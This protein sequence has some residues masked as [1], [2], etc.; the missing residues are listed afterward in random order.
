[1]KH[2]GHHLKLTC[3]VTLLFVLFIGS[4]APCE[5]RVP[6][7]DEAKKPFTII[8]LP[9]TQIY[10]QSF[11]DIFIKQTEW[12]KENREK[13]NIV[14]VLHEGDIT[15]HN[16]EP[17]WK[18][19]DK[20]MSILDDVVPYCMAPGNHD[21]GPGGGRGNFETEFLDKFFPPS[22]FEK[23]PWYG[24]VYEKHSIK[25][26]YYYIEANGTR[27]LVVCLEFGPRDKVLDWANKIVADNERLQTIVLTHNYM[28]SDDTRVGEGDAWNPHGYPN[29]G[30]DGEDMWEKFVSRHKNIFLVV[31]GHILHDGLGRLTSTGKN[32]NKVHQVLANYQMRPKGGSGWLRIMTFVPDKNKILVTTYSPL[33]EQYAEDAQNKFE[34]ENKMK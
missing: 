14:C 24:G 26:A 13:L 18:N 9:D 5:E 23:K 27:F 28:Y 25:N 31:S 6:K 1:M 19:A 2:T 20:A 33:L 21:T 30:N 32:G 10:A 22:R 3:C 34:L 4:F 11:P 15:N 8:A 17:Q 16:S 7:K 29:G 12:I